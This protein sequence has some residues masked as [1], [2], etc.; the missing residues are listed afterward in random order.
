MMARPHPAHEHVLLGSRSPNNTD[1]VERELVMSLNPQASMPSLATRSLLRLVLALLVSSLPFLI[2]NADAF[3]PADE[4][5]PTAMSG[6][7]QPAVGSDL[8]GAIMQMKPGSILLLKSGSY[9]LDSNTTVPAGTAAAPITITAAADQAGTCASV[10]IRMN[11]H[12]QTNNYVTI[13]GLTLDRIANCTVAT[14]DCVPHKTV[15]ITGSKSV[16]IRNNK[17]VSGGNPVYVGNNA[18]DIAIVGNLFSGAMSWCIAVRGIPTDGVNILANRFE[19]CADDNIQAEN[20]KNLVISENEFIGR[21]SDQ[22]L[23]LKVPQGNT[24][25]TRNW[26]DCRLN[27]EACVLFHADDYAPPTGLSHKFAHNTVLG[28]NSSKA[29]F[30]VMGGPKTYNYRDLVVEY[31]DFIDTQDS[32]CRVEFKQCDNCTFQH[33]TI[34]GGEVEKYSQAAGARFVDNIFSGTSLLKRDSNAFCSHN[35]FHQVSGSLGSCNATTTA[36]PSFKNPPMLLELATSSSSAWK[37][38][39]DGTHRGRW[40]GGTLN[41]LVSPTNLTVTS[42]P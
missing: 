14:A 25:I 3:G 6:A 16:V 27:G 17:F 31:N 5:C 1:L 20:Q 42:I 19:D 28:C 12:I 2:A 35:V 9:T 21:S 15:N 40:Q 4:N 13:A 36:D 37:N 10:V 18:S 33:N 30:I 39:S 32:K 23:D 26:L 7:L 29:K 8:A 11:G 24:I 34:Y 22:I 41:P 38:A